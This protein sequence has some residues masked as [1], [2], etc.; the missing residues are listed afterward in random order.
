[1][2]EDNQTSRVGILL[3]QGR[4]AEAEALLKNLLAA[5]AH[6]THLQAMLAETLLMQDKAEPAMEVI[7]MAIGSTP[8]EPY[9]FFV[10]ARVL[11]NQ[12]NY[13]EAE[14]MLATAISM[15]PYEAGYFAYAA[16]IKLI[17]KKFAEALEQADQALAIDPEHVL[18]LNA[19]STALQKLNRKEESFQTI[20][21]ALRED[22]NNA[23]THANYGWGLLEQGDHKKAM[24]HFRE[25]LKADP[26]NDYAQA[27]LL[28][29]IKAKNP[30]YRAF[31]KYG[32]FMNNLTA[33]YQWGVIIGIVVATRVLRAV[34]AANETLRPFL[35]PLIF[36]IGIIAF[37]TWVITPI[38]NLFLRFNKYGQFLLSKQEK[39]S[40]NVVASC[41]AI[42][43]IGL[44]SYLVLQDDRF[45][46]VAGFG[47]MMMVPGS[48]MF[49]APGGKKLLLY[50]GLG[51][52]LVGIAAMVQTFTTGEVMT[53]WAMIFVVGFV[54]FQWVSNFIN[55][56]AGDR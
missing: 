19:R 34:A 46:V 33:K 48:V 47:F 39:Q 17:R 18:A 45:I 27:G 53:I 44:V 21:G 23:Y 10:K 15:D 13:K 32:F 41:L 35:T 29:A 54:A 37:S 38:S 24:E 43:L 31:L 52:A 56:R 8:D 7:D 14:E 55:I 28:E 16:Q 36:L 5:D 1:M 22:P 40:A 9:L 50:Y 42:F 30:F 4:Y 20:Q 26:D 12:E 11:A 51:M 49:S 25:S 2:T 6:N 3:Q